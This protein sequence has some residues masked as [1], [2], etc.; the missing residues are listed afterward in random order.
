[1][2]ALAGRDQNAQPT[3][4][5][6][7]PAVGEEN[8]PQELQHKNLLGRKSSTDKRSGKNTTSRMLFAK[9]PSSCSGGSDDAE[10]VKYGAENR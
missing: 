4:T 3:N 10:L 7:Q 9:T 8:K 1:M 5:E 2:S 6:K